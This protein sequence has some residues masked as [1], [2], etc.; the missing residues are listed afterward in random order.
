MKNNFANNLPVI[1]LYKNKSKKSKVDTQLLYGENFRVLKKYKGWKKIKI[2]KDGYIG[3]VQNVNF[4]IPIKPNFKVSVLKAE[5]FSK[6]EP[7]K[8]KKISF[9]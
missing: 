3:Y 7:K 5:L 9:I 1:N 8:N 6:P 2:E 4:S